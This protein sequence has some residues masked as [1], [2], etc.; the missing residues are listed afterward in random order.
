MASPAILSAASTVDSS[1]S[2]PNIVLIMADDMGFSDIGCY[3]SEIA[4]PH[5]D[6][7]A[8][9]GLRFS[10]FYNCG[11]CCPTRA[12]LMT[13]L[14]PHQVGMGLMLRDYHFPGY[15]G[16]L[17][18]NC[19]T[20]AEALGL[21][22][23]QTGICGKWHLTPPDLKSKHNWPLQRGFG[24]FFGTING[25]GSYFEPFTLTQGNTPITPPAQGFYYTDAI[26]ENALGFMD[27]HARADSPFFLYVA[28]TAPHYP[29]QALPAD[30]EKYK[31]A[32]VGGWDKGRA[33]RYARMVQMG[34]IDKRWALSP[35]DSRVPPWEEAPYKEWEAH[36]M[37]VYAAQIARMDSGVGQIVSRI[38]QLGIEQNTLILF[39]SDNGG[40]LEELSPAVSGRASI[41]HETLAGQQ[42]RLGNNPAVLP[43]P[44]DTYQSYG[45]PWANLSNT[46]F[47]YYKHFAH[48]GGISTPLIARWPA[49]IKSRGGW[50]QQT[51]H[52]MDV[53]ATCIDLAGVEYPKIYQGRQIIPLEGKSLVPVLE[54]RQRAGHSA[55]YWEHQGNSAV[56][57]GSWKLVSSYPEY[58]E[59]HDMTADRTELVNL[60]DAHP[61]R[62][63][64]M[65]AMYESWAKRVGVLPWTLP[66]MKPEK[67]NPP[68]YLRRM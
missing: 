23:Y 54:G 27:S 12:S 29:L 43:G 50:T 20:I 46:P 62:V 3:G 39:L 6:A 11:R 61:D 52:V 63:Q 22:G 15:M 65:A 60:V 36:R 25:A 16:D 56:R 67:I 4:T 49:V 41:P 31:N 19:V 9:G 38:Q 1:G 51:G 14:Y 30:I 7:L 33:A 18:Q 58:W 17:S 32:Y 66:G 57:E 34:L 28:Y 8:A 68:K 59:L 42:V 35:R 55:I 37:A 5:I 24:H 47:R 45:L 40:N 13:G 21:A 2:R 10:Q 44:V 26:T 53:L 48:E 64:H